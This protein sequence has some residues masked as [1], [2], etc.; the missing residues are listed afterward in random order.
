M[1]TETETEKYF[2]LEITL[3]HRL[4]YSLKIWFVVYISVIFGNHILLTVHNTVAHYTHL[5]LPESLIFDSAV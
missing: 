2:T 3:V 1:E 4:S 5:G